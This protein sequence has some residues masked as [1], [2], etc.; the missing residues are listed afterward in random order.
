MFL[1]LMLPKH[2]GSEVPVK[3]TTTHSLDYQLSK[4]LWAVFDWKSERTYSIHHVL[5]NPARVWET[6]P[7]LKQR[8]EEAK[9]RPPF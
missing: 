1:K 3:V 8:D 9:C 7:D 5:Q 6:V 2:A 4:F